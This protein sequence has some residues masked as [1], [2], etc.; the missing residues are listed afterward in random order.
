MSADDKKQWRQRRAAQPVADF[1]SELLNPVIERRAGMTTDLIGQW[2]EIAG[3]R[4]AA[5]SRPEKLRWP[6]QASEDDP[7]EPATLVVACD[8]GHAVFLQHDGAV[9]IGRINTYFGFSAVSRLQLVQKPVARQETRERPRT[10]RSLEADGGKIETILSDVDD[11]KLKA[12]LEK[13]A[14]GV[15]SNGSGENG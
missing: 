1:V 11:P 7:F 6:R 10:T 5:C 9:I 4:H 8:G 3:P 13:M 12:A 2:E 15:F 14:R